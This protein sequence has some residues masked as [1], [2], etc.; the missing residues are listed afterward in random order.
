VPR[1]IHPVSRATRVPWRAVR[2]AYDRSRR[3]SRGW[4]DGAGEDIGG[5]VI[6]HGHLLKAVEA[7]VEVLSPFIAVE[8]S[9]LNIGLVDKRKGWTVEYT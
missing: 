1:P 7:G 5:A 6:L 3:D 9:L 2:P 8:I 4:P